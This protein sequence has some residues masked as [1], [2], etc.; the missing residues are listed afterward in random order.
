MNTRVDLYSS[1]RNF[2]DD[3]MDDVRKQTFG[4]DFGQNSWVTV[5]EYDRFMD[6]L[7]L[8]PDGHALEVACGSGGPALYLARATGCRVTG[9][10]IN[11]HGVHTATEM[12]ARLGYAERGRFTAVD[13]NSP[14]PSRKTRSMPSCALIQ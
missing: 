2:T 6:W 12:A 13:A 3:V 7:G 4:V 10:D 11:E 14:L 5:D 1:Y 8:G 9:V